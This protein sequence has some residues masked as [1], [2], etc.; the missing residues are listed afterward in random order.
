MQNRK[1]KTLEFI[2]KELSDIKDSIK[3]IK[4]NKCIDDRINEFQKEIGL[5]IIGALLA[6]LMNSLVDVI[7]ISVEMQFPDK[8]LSD[9][10]TLI[11][12][13]ILVAVSG[14]SL[15]K[16]RESMEK[17]IY[18]IQARKG[19]GIFKGSNMEEKLENVKKLCKSVKESFTNDFEI[20]LDLSLTDRKESDIEKLSENQKFNLLLEKLES[21][22]QVG[23]GIKKKDNSS[24]GRLTIEV[25]RWDEKGVTLEC[26]CPYNK[27][28]EE[29][30][31]KLEPCLNE[32]ILSGLRWDE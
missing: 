10:I 32:S 29:I 26:S 4:S 23:I 22:N 5:V 19:T 11:V 17:E 27:I 25:Q 15:M 14:Y 12:L 31:K 21:L 16:V 1:E 9:K 30:R 8:G 13:T 20:W 7:K 2:K 24:H 6:I 3:Q 18:H 28:G